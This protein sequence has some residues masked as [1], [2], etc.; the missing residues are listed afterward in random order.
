LRATLKTISA[1]FGS[2]VAFG[3]KAAPLVL[4]EAGEP[5]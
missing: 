1:S 3:A 5:S 4:T 2:C